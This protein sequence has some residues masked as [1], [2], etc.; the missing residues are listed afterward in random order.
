VGNI[1]EAIGSRMITADQQTI[2]LA[3]EI[4]ING[5]SLRLRDKNGAPLWD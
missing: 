3:R 4:T 5:R 1:L 2:V